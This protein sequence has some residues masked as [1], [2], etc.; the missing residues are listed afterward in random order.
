MDAAAP[1]RRKRRSPA[2]IMERLT[3]AAAREFMSSGFR[4]AT[5]A[6]I[7]RRADVTEAQLFRYFDSKAE[8]FRVAIFQP[9]NRSFADFNARQLANVNLSDNV[10]EQTCRYIADLQQFIAEHAQMLMCLLVA[11]AYAPDAIEGISD[12]EALGEYFNRGQTALSHRPDSGSKVDPALM[13]RVSFAAVLANV[14]FRNWMFPPGLADDETVEAAV[15]DFVIE[16]I[17][18]TLP[19]LV[20]D[21]AD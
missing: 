17:G 1:P 11:E 6:A 5:T 21:R 16:G 3:D 19:G 20:T 12:V 4:D 14:L 18:A 15:I 7:A 9:L 13:V 8:L 2:E 10:R